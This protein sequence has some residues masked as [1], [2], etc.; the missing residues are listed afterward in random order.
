MLSS[1][2]L[3]FVITVLVLLLLRHAAPRLGLL[4]ESGAHRLHGKP[5]PLVGGIS[6][7]IGFFLGILLTDIPL[8][9]FRALFFGCGL[10]VVVGVLDDVHEL[11]S[12]SRFVAQIIAALAMVYYGEVVLIGLGDLV[13]SGPV[14][15]GILAVPLTVFA[16]VGVINSMNMSDGMDGLAGG[17]FLVAFAS[18]AWVASGSGVQ[19]EIPILIM[20]ITGVSA[21]LLFNVRLGL[22]IQ[23]SVFLGDAGS[24]FMGFLLCWFLVRYSQPP[25]SVFDPVTAL[26]FMAIPLMDTVSVMLRRMLYRRSPFAADRSHV[27][28]I[29]QHA[30]LS[31]DATLLSILGC[32]VAAAAIGIVSQDQGWEEV[33]RFVLFLALFVVYFVFSGWYV[34][35]NRMTRE[36]VQT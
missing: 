24:M 16:T 29:L 33:F 18:M 27:H 7:F 13:G 34:H 17:L 20:V 19:S 26:W 5:T 8:G 2:L 21:F 3:M 4:A 1:Y 23:A 14:T 6:I 12:G 30:G 31:V 28:H 32:A 15:L 9:E 10:L 11:S 25:Y 36:N 22:R 35:V